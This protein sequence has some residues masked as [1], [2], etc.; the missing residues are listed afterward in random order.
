MCEFIT[1]GVLE[2]LIWGGVNLRTLGLQQLVLGK[3]IFTSFLENW[4]LGGPK[5]MTYMDVKIGELIV[6]GDARTFSEIGGLHEDVRRKDRRHGLFGEV[7]M[8]A[9]L[10]ARPAWPQ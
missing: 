10:R 3:M 9:V 2:T 7:L 8:D 5:V 6:P 1:Q 4:I